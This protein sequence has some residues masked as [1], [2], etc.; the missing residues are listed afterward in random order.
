[1]VIP[2]DHALGA[3]RWFGVISYIQSNGG[4]LDVS[5][6]AAVALAHGAGAVI[7]AFPPA[8]M[9][10]VTLTVPVGMHACFTSLFIVQPV[11]VS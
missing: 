10:T 7:A 3:L 6:G 8:R 1:V 2:L 4:T 9:S 11:P 5:G